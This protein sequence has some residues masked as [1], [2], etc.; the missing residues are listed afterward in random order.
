M[1]FEQP[2]LCICLASDKI[3]VVKICSLIKVFGMFEKIRW[4][5]PTGRQ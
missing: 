1:Q 4:N 5:D 2:D 3:K